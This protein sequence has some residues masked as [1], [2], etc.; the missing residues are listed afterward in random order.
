MKILKTGKIGNLA[1]NIEKEAG[2]GVALKVMKDADK[3]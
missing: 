1:R 2:L 3:F